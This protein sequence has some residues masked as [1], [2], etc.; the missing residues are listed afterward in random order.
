[1]LIMER[2]RY[3]G[4]VKAPM[5]GRDDAGWLQLWADYVLRCVI[6]RN[7]SSDREE[8]C[9]WVALVFGVVERG[10]CVR[11]LSRSSTMV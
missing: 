10:F 3:L 1:M 4:R 7:G 9:V 8:V 6:L 5:V 11:T 2:L